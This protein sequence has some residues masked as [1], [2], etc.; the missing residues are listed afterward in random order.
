[1][2]R[3]WWDGYYKHIEG[4]TMVC[5]ECRVDHRIIEGRLEG[6]KAGCSYRVQREKRM[7]MDY[8]KA[9]TLYFQCRRE[10][11]VIEG[12]LAAKMKPLKEKMVL[13]TQWIEEKAKLDGLKNVSV[14][15]LGTGYWTTTN[16]AKVNNRTAFKEFC[17]KNDLWDLMEIRAASAQ[18]KDHI[19]R[20][21]TVPAGVSFGQV[22][23][24][25]I[26]TAGEK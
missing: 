12:E 17:E 5:S 4:D 26:K 11:E 9:M 16:S 8:N 1:M 20:T 3:I 21:N 25:R 19:D 13:L 15:G 14:D 7:A 6:H 22:Q 10:V 2:S 24:F 18:I 23:V